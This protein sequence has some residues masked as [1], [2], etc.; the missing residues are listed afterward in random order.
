[1]INSNELAA[2]EELQKAKMELLPQIPLAPR[3]R[4]LLVLIKF[5]HLRSHRSN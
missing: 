1:M 4:S 2:S 3:W 5:Q